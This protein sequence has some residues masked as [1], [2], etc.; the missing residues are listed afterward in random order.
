[1]DPYIFTSRNG[2]HIIDLV[3]TAKLMEDAYSFVRNSAEQG[4]RF[5]FIGTK[6]QAAGIVSPRS[7]SMRF[8]LR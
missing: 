7:Q 3:Q 8:S 1:M 2:V 4:Q 6:R 5:L